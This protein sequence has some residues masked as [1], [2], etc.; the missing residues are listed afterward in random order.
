MRRKTITA[1]L[2]CQVFLSCLTLDAG[3]AAP[4][5]SES[6]GTAPAPA[7]EAKPKDLGATI[8]LM[9]EKIREAKII[10]PGSQLRLAIEDGSARVFCNRRAKDNEVDCKINAVLIARALLKA[11]DKLVQ[12]TRV[13]FG[14][15]DSLDLWSITISNNQVNDFA[16]HQM[17][18]KALLDTVLLQRVKNLPQLNFDPPF[19][20]QS[21]IHDSVIALDEKRFPVGSFTS[22]YYQLRA[23]SQYSDDA[24]PKKLMSLLKNSVYAQVKVVNDALHQDLKAQIDAT[25]S[26]LDAMSGQDRIDFMKKDLGAKVPPDGPMFEE[27]LAQTYWVKKCDEWGFIQNYYKYRLDRADNGARANNL[28]AVLSEMK[29]MPTK[30][31][32]VRGRY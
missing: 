30:A 15:P 3:A 11:D 24:E 25:K 29:Y 14:V 5:V 7:S 21:V 31:D 27:R 1:A 6:K 18:E 19:P 10:D 2:M 4:S 32:Q 17:T 12:S 8:N 20:E 26:Q 16:T 9:E 28:A 23:G 22:L 13:L